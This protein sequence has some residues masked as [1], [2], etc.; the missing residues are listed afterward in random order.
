MKRLASFLETVNEV[1]NESA[2]GTP[3]GP[4]SFAE[5]GG[6]PPRRPRQVGEEAIETG[7]EP[8]AEERGRTRREE[9]R[10]SASHPMT[11]DRI[12]MALR[13]PDSFRAA[14]LMREVLDEPLARRPR[15]H[16][17]R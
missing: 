11:A 10:P 14:V 8:T 16:G 9:A 4:R 7:R 6:P 15:R 5:S 17:G 13:D 12:R 1:R 2:S 3:G